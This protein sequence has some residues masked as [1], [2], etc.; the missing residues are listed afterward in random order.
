MQQH[1]IALD[2]Q[3]LHFLQPNNYFEA[4]ITV[5]D[6]DVSGKEAGTS[7]TRRDIADMGNDYYFPNAALKLQL[8]DKFSFGLLYDQPFGADCGI[9]GAKMYLYQ[10]APIQF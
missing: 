6:P 5:L 7:A 1:W 3:C 2:N 10:I 9:F 4:G 8:N